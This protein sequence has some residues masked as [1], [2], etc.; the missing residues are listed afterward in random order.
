MSPTEGRVIKGLAMF[1]IDRIRTSPNN[2]RK[3]FAGIEELASSIRA[4]GLLHPI[5][6]QDIPGGG[7]QIVDGHRRHAAAR[8]AGLQRVP[9]VVRRDMLP[10]DELIA[11]L[12][13]NG[14]RAGLDPVEEARAFASLRA[15]GHSVE[16]I[17]ARNGRSVAYVRSRLDLLQLPTADQEAIRNGHFSAT[18]G[19]ELIRAQRAADRQAANP[20][21]RPVG[22]PKGATTKPY[23]GDTHP[24]AKAARSLCDHRGVP[25]VAGTACGPCWEAVIRNDAN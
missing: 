25:K 8:L 5:L 17:A 16:T 6:V 14:Q 10:D 21:A 23:F 12:V 13:A 4:I 3:V 15:G 19:N 18:Y 9:C 1:D 2:P 7:F 11:M 20:V 24:L 22:R